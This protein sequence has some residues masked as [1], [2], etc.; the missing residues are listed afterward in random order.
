MENLGIFENYRDGNMTEQEKKNFL[1]RL[2]NDSSFEHEYKIYNEV[3]DFIL[4]NDKRSKFN[5]VLKEVETNYFATRKNNSIFKNKFALKV[6]ASVAI[7]AVSTILLYYVFQPKLSN[8]ELFAQYYN[9][10]KIDEITRSGNDS[11]TT[12]SN[13]FIAY[14]NGNYQ[15]SLQILSSVVVS[16]ELKTPVN[17]VN[18][19]SYLELGNFKNAEKLIFE[20]SKDV[21]NAYYDDCLWYLSLIYL[22]TDRPKQAIPLLEKLIE[23]KSVYNNMAVELLKRID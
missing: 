21:Y 15:K 8:K 19:L 9:T 11:A 6:A 10:L 1:L 16:D 20:A 18:G 22:R 14:Q 7:I 4:N 23:R 2:A 5:E 17:L 12:I 13:G 3:N